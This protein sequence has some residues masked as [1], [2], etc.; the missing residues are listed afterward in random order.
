[1]ETLKAADITREIMWNI[2]SG[3]ETLMYVLTFLAMTIAIF[4]FWRRARVWKKGVSG[5]LCFD[6]PMKRLL[7]TVK[8]VSTHQKIFQKQPEGIYHL[9][10]FY[11]F[12][13]LLFVTTMVALEHDTP[14]HFFYGKT[15]LALSFMGD[16]GGV[17][18]MV[19][20]L[21]FIVRRFIRKPAHISSTKPF[22]QAD[23]FMILII[24]V[25][26]V[27]GYFLQGL[28]I[29][30]NPH[31]Y[32]IEF[33]Q[34]IEKNMSF[35]GWPMGMMFQ[36]LM[37]RE[38]LIRWH[39]W[40]WLIHMASTMV[41]IALLPFTKLSHMILALFNTFTQ[42]LESKGVMRKIPFEKL[43]DAESFG[44]AK[45]TEFTWK[46]RMAVD[47]CVE[48]GRCDI[49]CPATTTK[50]PLSPKQIVVKLRD[51]M[52]AEEKNKELANQTVFETNTISF[53]E[54][55]SCTTCGACVQECPV[56]IEHVE[57]IT[58]MRRYL[59]LTEGKLP[60]TAREMIR[61]VTNNGNPWGMA[62]EDRFQWADG[63]DVPVAD[64]Q[65]EIDY[66]YYVGCAGSY[67]DSNK[68]VAQAV[69]KLMKKAGVSFAV[70]GKDEKCNGDPVRRIGDE[71]S[72][73]EIAV[74]CVKDLNKYKF[75]KVV[76]HCPHCFHT[77]G[78]EYGAFG[79]HYDVLHHSQLFDDLLKQGKLKT[80]KN[81]DREM[82]FHDPCYLGRHGGEYNAP[83]E[84]LKKA[85]I[86][87]KD[88][89]QSK[90]KSFCCGMGGGN[91]WYEIKEGTNMT[92]HRMEQLLT[93]SP[94]VATACSYCL[95]NFEYG[96]S[97]KDKFNDLKVTDIAEVLLE[98]TE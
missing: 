45:T 41:F 66:L 75:K 81:L 30:A 53:D 24:F 64:P 22:L 90:E 35:L 94:N 72:F 34:N 70:I 69:V 21:F 7:L 2:T 57:L 36:K 48:C 52:W 11:G 74:Q 12:M 14:L 97:T 33:F 93:K 77:I 79:G 38:E 10:I 85:G 20:L 3:Q 42:S 5:P 1:M 39:Q 68:R 19:G 92:I 31:N 4:G 32:E 96:K 44:V 8:Q 56:N 60:P 6:R 28:R 55:F 23:F 25:L 91:M 59:V 50:K 71:Y 43:E 47:T 89:E 46:Q 9:L 26:V 16:L 80:T 63:L 76:T 29:G 17:M 84:V 18:V 67:D 95:I 73:T 37:V 58:D 61:K 62:Q 98:A 40:M 13:L 27:Q 87:V 78:K 49:V 54:L 65:T 83:R 82:V 86:Q 15:Y 51:R 88:H